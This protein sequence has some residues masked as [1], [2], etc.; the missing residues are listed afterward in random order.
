MV[1]GRKVIA[2]S[3]FNILPPSGKG[4]ESRKKVYEF[5]NFDRK[6]SIGIILY[7]IRK[8]LRE[9]K[10]TVVT[11]RSVFHSLWHNFK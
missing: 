9:T 5:L 8:K 11:D 7:R 1:D 3:Q 4:S 2:L 6:I 10:T